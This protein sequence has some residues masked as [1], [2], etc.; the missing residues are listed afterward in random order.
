MQRNRDKLLNIVKREVLQLRSQSLHHAVIINLVRQQPPQQL[1]RS[2][3]LEVKVGK[4]PIF[5]L[6]DQVNIIQ[7][8]DRMKG[9]LLIL[10][11]P[12]GG[13]TTTLLE[14]ARR[15]VIRA[16]K[17]QNLPIPVLLDLSTWENP[18]HKISD[19]LVYQL[20]FK[21]NI[22]LKVTRE[23]LENKLILPLI[24][25]FDQVSPELSEYCLEEINKL[26]VDFQPKHLVVCSSFAAYK[27]CYNKLRVNAAV[28]LQPLKNSHIKDYLLASRSRELWVYIQDEPELLN[29]AKIPLMLSMMTLAYEEILIAAWRRITSKQIREKYLLNAYVR[30]QL[31]VENKD[32]WYSRGQEP[33][34]EQTRRWL[35]WLAKR[36]AAENIQE[37]TI[38]KLQ[39]SWLDTNGE[40]QAYK[41]IVNLIS[42]L[43]WG[44]TFGFIFGYVWELKEG[45]ISGTIGGLIGGKLGFPGLKNLVLRIVLFNNGHIPWNYRRFLN[46]ASSQLLLQRIGDRY[47]FIHYLLYKHFT[48]I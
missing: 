21:Y 38:K 1:K 33:L 4:R 12:G 40:L 14:L 48:E 35:A 26:S 29:L 37:F 39:P 2:W 41:L 30:F 25:G 9:K 28:L 23:W 45:L 19:W 31:G 5:K 6:P 27:N 32:K 11:N 7:V 42:I 16:E 36:M 34:P 20:K 44:F 10:G 17:E 24:D 13:K 3:E 18:N 46:Y 8:F 15:L 22:S 43:F 47:Q